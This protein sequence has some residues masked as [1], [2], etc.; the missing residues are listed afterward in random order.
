MDASATAVELLKAAMWPAV[1]GIIFWPLRR[2]IKPFSK[3]VTGIAV[4]D[5]FRLDAAEVAR[6]GNQT[7][8]S[9]SDFSLQQI[10]IAASIDRPAGL[11]T[12]AGT[13][14]PV[15]GTNVA[16]AVIKGW[17]LERLWRILTS[18]QLDLVRLAAQGVP[19][20]DADAREAYGT[21]DDAIRN[22]LPYAAFT[23]YLVSQRLLDDSPEGF[24]I[25]WRG[26]ELLRFIR[27]T[28]A[29]DAFPLLPRTEQEISEQAARTMN[30]RQPTLP[31]AL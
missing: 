31:E 21:L 17:G 25:A 6:I 5:T 13:D 1:F 4:G 7:I 14:T 26:D 8:V 24:K 9:T 29:G 23:S 30:Q 10:A 11:V 19:V 12:F 15:K 18:A 27:F 16:F 20:S 22:R 3:R 2:E 28:N